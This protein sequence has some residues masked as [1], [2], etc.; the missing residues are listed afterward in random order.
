M[1]WKP[2]KKKFSLTQLM[3][4]VEEV[5][6][7][8]IRVVGNLGPCKKE[9]ISQ[10]GTKRNSFGFLFWWEKKMDAIILV[11]THRKLKMN[12]SATV[13]DSKSIAWCCSHDMILRLS[14]ALLQHFPSLWLRIHKNQSKEVC[15]LHDYPK[16]IEFF[17][18][19]VFDNVVFINR[20]GEN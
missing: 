9:L 11:C 8:I 7:F 10:S 2:D 16:N 3:G 17:Q 15:L 5:Y 14:M 12:A 4:L 6:I 19:L 13:W 18:V 1:S 20:L